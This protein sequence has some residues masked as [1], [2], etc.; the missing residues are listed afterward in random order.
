MCKVLTKELID[1][2]LFFTLTLN[3]S[4]SYHNFVFRT[5]KCEVSDE[6]QETY[7]KY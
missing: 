7:E 1:A 4:R 3:K 6:I 5:S 2:K